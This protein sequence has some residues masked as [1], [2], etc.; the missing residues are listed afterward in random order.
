MAS[1][2]KWRLVIF[3]IQWR[4]IYTGASKAKAVS[5]ECK[6]LYFLAVKW[7][8]L[9][10]RLKLSCKQWL[11][12]Y[13]F[14]LCCKQQPFAVRFIP[15]CYNCL[16]CILGLFFTVN[17]G[18]VVLGLSAVQSVST[19]HVSLPHRGLHK[20]PAECDSWHNK[21][22]QQNSQ[23]VQCRR[24]LVSVCKSFLHYFKCALEHVLPS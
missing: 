4:R 23:F 2:P 21:W 22:F 14:I 8:V 18:F 5:L 1:H 19:W 12:F 3:E 16:S 9:C 6:F 20:L 17:N 15:C 10:S 11:H 13:R 7:L 24:W